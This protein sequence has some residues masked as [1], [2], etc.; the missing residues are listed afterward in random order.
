[1]LQLTGAV[2][3]HAAD[4]VNQIL[5]ASTRAKGLVKQ[6]L[7]LSKR[8]RQEKL[9]LNLRPLVRETSDFLRSSLPSNIQLI[10]DFDPDAGLVSADPALMQQAVMNICTNAAQA[11]EKKGGVL[12]LRLVNT[13]WSQEDVDLGDNDVAELVKLSISDTGTGIAPENMDRIFEPYFTTR[14]V[15]KGQGS[16]LAVVHGIVASHGGVIKVDSV[17]GEGTTF[18][19]YL[20]RAGGSRSPKQHPSSCQTGKSGC[21]L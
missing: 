7:T 13:A 12:A 6:I 3:E 5:M 11:M 14:E 17:V 20:P 2:E 10:T 21:L 15:G 18:H 16:G 9:P 19:V 8:G 1:M 4:S